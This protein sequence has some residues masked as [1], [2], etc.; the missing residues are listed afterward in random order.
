LQSRKPNRSADAASDIQ[1]IFVR[2]ELAEILKELQESGWIAF[3][4]RNSR[5]QLGGR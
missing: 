4:G 5:D 2:L 3:I 1:H